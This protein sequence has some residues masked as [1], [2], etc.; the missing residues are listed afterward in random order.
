MVPAIGTALGSSQPLRVYSG[1]NDASEVVEERGQDILSSSTSC[2][3]SEL[4]TPRVCHAAPQPPGT[5]E[6]RPINP[7]GEFEFVQL[8]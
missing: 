4:A 5:D 3:A 7:P 1:H 2:A 8:P 6:P